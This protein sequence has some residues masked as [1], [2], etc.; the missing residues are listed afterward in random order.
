MPMLRNCLNIQGTIWWIFTIIV[1]IGVKHYE[2]LTKLLWHDMT[3]VTTRWANSADD[4][5]IF[6]L[7]SQKTGFQISCRLSPVE[8]ETICLKCQNLFSGKK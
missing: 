3:G 1:Y 7:F 4:K 8:I 6:F 2:C 5:L